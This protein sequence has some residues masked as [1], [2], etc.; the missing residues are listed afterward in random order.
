MFYNLKDFFKKCA[1]EID[2]SQIA[3]LIRLVLFHFV[4]VFYQ[5]APFHCGRVGD[6]LQPHHPS[7]YRYLPHKME[8]NQVILFKKNSCVSGYFINNSGK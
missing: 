2:I 8:E 7:F 1:I 6:P 4:W 5:W 3:G